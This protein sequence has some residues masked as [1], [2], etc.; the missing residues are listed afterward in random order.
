[1]A[2]VSGSFLR[3]LLRHKP[4]GIAHFGPHFDPDVLLS[5][6]RAKFSTINFRA[7]FNVIFASLV[8]TNLQAVLA[9]NGL[10]N[11]ATHTALYAAVFILSVVKLVMSTMV[12]I[13]SATLRCRIVSRLLESL[14]TGYH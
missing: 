11:Q 2:S 8:L 6:K 10:T 7:L 9:F 13:S 3:A 14:D 5:K 4:D 1:M 12:S